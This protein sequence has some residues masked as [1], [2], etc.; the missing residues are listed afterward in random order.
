MG[1][2]LQEI[3]HKTTGQEVDIFVCMRM[4]KAL[5]VYPGQYCQPV[6]VIVGA[7]SW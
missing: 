5:N 3:K 6:P 2:R 1:K 4:S 7:S